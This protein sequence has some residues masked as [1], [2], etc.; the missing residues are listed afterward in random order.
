MKQKLISFFLVAVFLLTDFHLL[1]GWGSWGHTHI[2]RA[3]VFALPTPMRMFYFNHIDFITE[4]AV[5]PDLRRGLLNDKA[6]SPRHYIDMEEFGNIPADEFPQT[7]AQAYGE[8]TQSFLD[9]TG[10]LPWYIQT[11]TTK[12]T[13]AFSQRNKEAILFLSAE[14]GHYVADAH[15]PL[16]T[17]SNFNGQLTGQKGIHAL[18]ESEIPELFGNAYNFRTGPATYLPDITA[19]TWK[20]IAHSHSLEDSVLD[21][22]RRVRESFPKDKMY[23]IDA[24]GHPVLFYNEPVYSDSYAKEFNDQMH[25]MVKKQLWLS[26]QDVAN[27][28]YTAWVNAGK[29]NLDS[30]DDPHLFKENRENYLMEYKAWEKGKLLNLNISRSR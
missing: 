23:K 17:A 24:Q 7:P 19:A 14:L 22:D 11:M 10:Y 26:I 9:K 25:G 5:V 6:E 4:G 27:F 20:I 1:F 15:M 12:L 21:A 28:W 18:W 8:Y 29:P 2:N 30:L 16:H 13:H 3:A